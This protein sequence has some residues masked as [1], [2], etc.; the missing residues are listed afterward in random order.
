MWIVYLLMLVV[1]IA[2][3]SAQ[4]AYMAGADNQ[5]IVAVDMST[6][7]IIAESPSYG[8]TI[9]SIVVDGNYIYA[10]GETTQTIRK[11]NLNDLTYTNT[12]SPNYEG[13]IWSIV[14]DGDYV[15][16]GG[17]TQT[18]KK[19]NL[20]DLTYTNIESPS[21]GATIR[22]IV[23]DG[24]YIY[25]GGETTQTIRKY[26]LDDLTYT[27]IESPN[28]GGTI[29]SIVVTTIIPIP[30][31][32]YEVNFIGNEIIT[33]NIIN[34]S[35]T[36]IRLE[37]NESRTLS[38]LGNESVM[39]GNGTYTGTINNVDGYSDASFE[40]TV[41]GENKT[42]NIELHDAELTINV[43]DIVTSDVVNNFSG[44]ISNSEYD[45]N[46]S[47]NTTTGSFLAPLKKN[48]NYT[49]FIDADNYAL[50]NN[51][52]TIYLNETSQT[53]NFS[54]YKTNS[55]DIEFRD[56]ETKQLITTQI[57][58]EMIGEL[59]SYNHTTTTGMLNLTF[60]IPERYVLR[61]KTEGYADGF[62]MTRVDDRSY[63]TLT[64]YMVNETQSSPVTITII[65]EGAKPVEGA[66]VKSLKYDLT[67]NSYLLQEVRETDFAG[68]TIFNIRKNAEYYRFIVEI[69]GVVVRTT[70]PSYVTADNLNIQIVRSG[71]IAGEFFDLLG[72]TSMITYNNVTKNFR[73]E[74]NDVSNIGSEYCLRVF[75]LGRNKE[76]LGVECS[77]SPSGVLLFNHEVLDGR[78]YEAELYLKINPGQT[79]NKF[80]LD[81]SETFDAG[82]MGLLL[83]ILF[84][85]FCAFVFIY[86]PAVGAVLTP[87]SLIIGRVLGL[88]ALPWTMITPLLVVGVIIAYLIDR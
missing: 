67:T 8:G 71:L 60:L 23:V 75:R 55:I 9:Q 56:D 34:I 86:N 3:A 49:V 54:F 82:S 64:I 42:I 88:N 59:A 66:V 32:D 30:V 69:D 21:Y 35:N 7:E 28:Y 29:Q 43:F 77:T 26:N 2:G 61:Y 70:N 11:Y 78:I 27:N 53:E 46:L 81:L 10:G 57:N 73:A 83:Q 24:D 16:A 84:T 68:E 52:R 50:F 38:I 80:V 58:F 79:I 76:F 48:L 39:I 87:F 74:Y 19:Y 5:T 12:E 6:G 15:Y 25:A 20:N 47:F 62:Y 45:Y 63:S 1:T 65:D 51:T 18:I 36:S 41:S 72:I 22:S 13:D 85:L 40:F 4:I 37:D 17:T 31:G 33:N 14:V 44:W